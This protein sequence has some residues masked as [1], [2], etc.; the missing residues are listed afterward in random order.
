MSY[1]QGRYYGM[2]GYVLNGTDGYSTVGAWLYVHSAITFEC[3]VSFSSNSADGYLT[4]ECSNDNF[5][6]DGA[7][8]NCPV[9]ALHNGVYGVGA[10]GDPNDLI[11][12]AGSQLTVSG[13]ATPYRIASVA[14]TSAWIR[15][16]YVALVN[17]PMTISA[18]FCWKTYS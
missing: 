2:D 6:N 15:V 5:S 7:S 18:T 8:Q 10:Y 12:V 9:S 13:N 17:V 1:K 14:N 4:L 3:I 11:T 16:K